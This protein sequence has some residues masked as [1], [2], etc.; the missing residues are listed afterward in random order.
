MGRPNKAA[1]GGAEES[2]KFGYQDV[3]LAC[4]SFA[5]LLNQLFAYL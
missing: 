4:H 2:L 3:N 1:Q 5:D